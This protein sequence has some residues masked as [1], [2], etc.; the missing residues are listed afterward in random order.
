MKLFA[1]RE[2]QSSLLFRPLAHSKSHNIFICDDTTIGCA[3]V[4]NPV[5]GWDS[6]CSKSLELALRQDQYPDGS[7]L[8][9]S[10]MASPDVK[11]HLT[12]SL[13]LRDKCCGRCDDVLGVSQ[14]EAMDYY[15]TGTNEAV[16]DYQGTRVRDFK[17]VVTYK[18]PTETNDV[19][20]R[21][22]EQC[23]KIQKRLKARLKEAGINPAEMTANGYV[24]L[25]S[26]FLH[27]KDD[28]LWMKGDVELD[29][30][31]PIN[32]T[33]LQNDTGIKEDTDG[34]TITSGKHKVFGKQ[35]TAKKFPKGA[36]VGNAFRW[37]GDPLDGG[38]CVTN[39]FIITVNIYFPNSQS[40]KDSIALKRGQ[41][42]RNSFD[43]MVHFA[44]KI[45]DMRVELDAVFDS[46]EDG[47]KPIQVSLEAIVF[48]DS[49]ESA[50]EGRTALQTYMS[51]AGLEMV[52]EYRFALPSF[53]QMLPF[54]ACEQAVKISRR[55]STMSTKFVLPI[56]P[57]FSDWKG[58]GTSVIN[59]VSRTGQL[60][61]LDLYDSDTNYNT[62]I[63]AESGAG[64][65]FL[66]N[67]I[68]RAYL[69]MGHKSW[70]IDA[71][72]SYEKIS[73]TFD[74][75]FIAFEKR[76]ESDHSVNPFSMI[77]DGDDDAFLD[78]LEMLAGCVM[79]MAFTRDEPSDLQAS[80]VERV[81]TELWKEKG[82]KMLMDDVAQR[83]LDDGDVRLRDVGKQ[84]YAFTTKGQFGHYFDKPHNVNF[85]GNLN[86]LEL[87]GLSKTPRL[88]A[89]VLFMMMFQISNEM[90][91][92]FKHDRN[93][94]RLVIID[95]A[96]DLLASSMAVAQFI[97]K[98]FRRFRKYNG[99]GI[100]VTQSIYD[101][102]KSDA[103]KAIAENAANSLILKQKSS[104]IDKA[105]KD[106]LM[107]LSEG[108]YRMLKQV[109][110]IDKKYSE[111]FI[112]TNKGV[113]VGRLIVDPFRV[114]MYS[115]KAADNTKIEGHIERGATKSEAM[116]LAALDAG[117]FR[118]D[119]KAIEFLK[120]KDATNS[121]F[122]KLFEGQ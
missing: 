2:N 98:G 100:V 70:C 9:F 110:T 18:M 42:I 84:L 87:D 118:F 51:D 99:A 75:N 82:N 48:G 88:Q 36:H 47:A 5:S 96:W 26:P 116:K 94:K 77:P 60:M 33:V 46:F 54:G 7:F 64:K 79:A 69:S 81:L 90:Y 107:S 93:V 59:L 115:T 34:I 35:L 91:E 74:G 25:L 8:S 50:E 95:E 121:E 30:S 85:K 86:I 89:V 53:I 111:I 10:L 11:R 15:W 16:E 66:T 80:E 122:T 71:G 78:S 37:F 38:G 6:K 21:E 39:N 52:S 31:R 4:C 117:L 13:E 3:F 103:G 43:A 104:T 28:A 63:Y 40:T 45:K 57:L 108:S 27:S 73:E 19:T 114:M 109:K 67:E 106:N 112:N 32:E 61:T 49:E 105:E 83:C 72:R 17:L 55:Y 58:T 23:R 24:N 97:E 20:E 113:G 120:D 62:L 76:G 102:Q 44:P 14:K 65:S 101:L 56:L 92:E 41:Y 12:Q 68:Q 22:Y 29:E 119:L 1:P